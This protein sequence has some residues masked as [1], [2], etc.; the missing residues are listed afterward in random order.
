MWGDANSR[1]QIVSPYEGNRSHLTMQTFEPLAVQQSVPGDNAGTSN[2]LVSCNVDNRPRANHFAT[3]PTT[4]PLIPSR[5]VPQIRPTVPKKPEIFRSMPTIPLS[6][7]YECQPYCAN[8]PEAFI[9]DSDIA[10]SEGS[11]TPTNT[12]KFVTSSMEMRENWKYAQTGQMRNSVASS[13][14]SSQ[15]PAPATP[16]RR[17]STLSN[18]NAITMGTLKR[19]GCSTYEEV[20]QLV[21]DPL[22]AN[23]DEIRKLRE[24]LVNKGV[25]DDKK[26]LTQTHLTHSETNGLPNSQA[27]YETVVKANGKKCQIQLNSVIVPVEKED[28][29]MLPLPPPPPEAYSDNEA[30]ALSSHRYNKIT[31]IHRQFLETLNN[32]LAVQ[33]SQRLSPR[34]TKRRSMSLT[35]SE[36]SG[37][38][39]SISNRV[40]RWVGLFY[41]IICRGFPNAVYRSLQS[42]AKTDLFGLLSSC[43]IIY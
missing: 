36:D 3:L 37:S 27:I 38:D 30:A 13:N 15:K 7:Y 11:I 25:D 2:F 42:S 22:Y 29:Q 12:E 20:K 9:D 16:V 43:R 34:L 19:V 23:L 18:P 21:R 33:Q 32:K 28:P 26:D 31:N 8:S 40:Q 4:K 14:S 24:N 5:Q 10:C 1:P 35:R 41:F 17:T 39:N 6:L